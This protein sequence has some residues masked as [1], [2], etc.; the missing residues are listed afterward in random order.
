LA[1]WI[2]EKFRAW[3]DSNG[4]VESR[5]SRDELLTNLMIYWVSGCITSSMRLYYEFKH[6]EGLL[7][8]GERVEVPTAFA[9]FPAE[10]LRPP[11][12]WVERAYNIVHWS[13]MPWGG[14]FAA[15][16]APELLVADI[17]SSF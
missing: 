5:I 16:E 13:S 17:R 1:A 7:G 10:I 3:S 14:H 12:S 9:D 15:L 4:D 8:P 2:V 6:N 11:R